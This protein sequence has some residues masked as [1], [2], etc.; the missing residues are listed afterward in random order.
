MKTK[1]KN[2]PPAVVTERL[3]VEYD[4]FGPWTYP[5]R[6]PDEMPPRFDPWYGELKDSILILKL[7]RNVERRDAKPGDDLY[8]RLLAV[9]DKGIVYL[10]LSQ[11]E[12]SR[13]DIAYGDIA[14]VRLI[15]ELLFG[16]LCIDLA[17][18]SIVSATF[19]TVSADVFDSFI[20]AVRANCAVG[21]GSIRFKPPVEHGPEPSE[22]DMLFQ[23]LLNA[24]RQRV[25]GLSVLGYQPPCLLA[26]TE[27]AR[28]GLVGFVA[29]LL[30]WRLDGCLLTA[31]SLELIMF[32]RGAGVPRIGKSKGFRYEAIYLPARSFKNAA[33][34]ARFLANGAPIHA[35]RISS[36]G[37][38]YELL[39]EKDPSYV[40]S[41]I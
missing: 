32:V 34:E 11:G 2:E 24:L 14:A 19:N 25:A 41:S 31:S 8:G 21:D 35:L 3:R 13:Q 28:R 26:S 1:P 27:N 12:I 18:G 5:V 40:L 33:V 4:R 39:F 16:Q 29:R 22:E 23:N 20:D 37:H 10:R 9:A 38:S 30:R 36:V 17:D 7:P 15:Q 6:S